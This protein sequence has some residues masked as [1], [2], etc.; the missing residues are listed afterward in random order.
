MSHR[1]HVCPWWMGYFLIHPLRR[2]MQDPV[3]IL[4]PHVRKGMTVLEIGP[5]MGY[6]TITLARMVGPTGKVVAVDIQD[7]MLSALRKQAM[8]NGMS[9]RVETRIT[10]PGSLGVSDLSGR[11]DFAFAFAV[12]HEV[13]DKERLSEEVHSALKPGGTLFM[14]DPVS[15]F[16]AKSMTPPSRAPLI[17]DSQ[18]R[19]N[20]PS[21]EAERSFS[22][23]TPEGADLAYAIA[24]KYVY[25]SCCNHPEARI[26][27]ADRPR[28]PFPP[29][30]HAG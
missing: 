2:F 25:Q 16:R 9:D 20:P 3:K 11:V 5:G 23:K 22:G 27:H 12:V 18:K 14:A 17:R 10:Q 15:H 24:G 6:F 28:H 8:T 19:P 26:T 1:H 29:M 21:G 30:P 4:A 13:P 7:K